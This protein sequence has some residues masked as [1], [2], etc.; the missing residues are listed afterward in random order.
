MQTIKVTFDDIEENDH[1]LDKYDEFIEI[2][3]TSSSRYSSKPESQI[4][5]YLEF[6]Y[7]SKK[8]K[9]DREKLIKKQRSRNKKYILF[10]ERLEDEL[11]KVRMNIVIK[12]GNF[13]MGDRISKE[14][15]IPEIVQKVVSEDIKIKMLFEQKRSKE[16]NRDV[17]ESIPPLSEEILGKRYIRNIIEELAFLDKLKEKGDDKEF[18]KE[19][20]NEIRKE[21]LKE[22][23]QQLEESL[24]DISK[25]KKSVKKRRI[26][27]DIDEILDKIKEEGSDSLSDEEKEFL[28][29]YSNEL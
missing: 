16:E 12:A 20:M 4:D 11:E 21:S 17:V 28:D 18:S 10:D 13:V 25:T 3:R 14:A 26:D 15:D 23:M 8:A 5:I 24:N 19:E 27:F 22:A 29:K 6:G 9:T 1:L 7:F 2:L